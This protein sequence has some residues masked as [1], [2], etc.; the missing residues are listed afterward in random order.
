MGRPWLRRLRGPGVRFG[1]GVS[2]TRWYA[3]TEGS[4][5]PDALP[6]RSRRSLG[7]QRAG[8][9]QRRAPPHSLGKNFSAS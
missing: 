5:A 6:G 4:P 7:A 8:A 9:S 3:D 1:A 2:V